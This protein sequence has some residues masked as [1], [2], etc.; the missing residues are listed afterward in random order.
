[1]DSTAGAYYRVELREGSGRVQ[2]RRLQL[3]AGGAD[4]HV[5]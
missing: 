3:G 5:P 1:M 4:L 2:A